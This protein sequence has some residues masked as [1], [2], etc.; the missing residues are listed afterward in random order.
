ME[1]KNRISLNAVKVWRQSGMISAAVMAVIA[2]A[3]TVAVNKLDW[4]AWVIYGA[5]GALVLEFILYVIVIPSL[6]WKWWR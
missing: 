6:R 5:W 2:I 4:S 1:L 3:L